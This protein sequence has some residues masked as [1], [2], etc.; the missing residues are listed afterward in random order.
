MMV[1]VQLIA[2]LIG[3]VAGAELLVRGASRL[4]LAAGLSP[5]VV[6]LTVVAFGTSSPEL[7]TSVTASLKGQAGLA[8]GNV[9]GSNIFNVL[10]ILG[11]AA[12]AA[13]LRITAQIVRLDV[14]FMLGV[15]VLV[16]LLAMDLRFSR[17]EGLLLVG[18]L[19]GYTAAL[20]ALAR[21]TGERDE[22]A[23][24]PARDGSPV[25]SVLLVAAGLGLLVVG[26]NG[27]VGSAL[28]IAR[29]LGLSEL[30]IGLTI[31]AAGTSLPELATS[32]VATVRGQRD[33]AVGNVIGSNT[34][35]LLCVLGG[36]V[37]VAGDVPV[38]PEA[39]RFDLP[40]MLAVALACFPMLVTGRTLSRAEGVVL[41]VYYL[42]YTGFLL[43]DAAEHDHLEAFSGVMLAFVIPLT[44]IGLLAGLAGH[45][46]AGGSGESAA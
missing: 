28:V 42:A 22:P 7:A 24:E 18:L 6:G 8:L 40:V 35:N 27:L 20:V 25:A 45:W 37:L 21:R 17:G 34:F 16:P 13:P 5:L 33:I 41:V 12:I 29:S 26:S 32:V 46:R 23:E 11:L 38:A 31:V 43:L 9:V 15:S 10:V 36:A 19:V 39:L 44:A 3:L 30:I 4:A 2:G 1:W 14:P